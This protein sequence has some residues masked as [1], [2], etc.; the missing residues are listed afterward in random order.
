M[1]IEWAPCELFIQV[2][3]HIVAQMGSMWGH[4]FV[5][6]W[7]ISKSLSK[8]NEDSSLQRTTF[9]KAAVSAAARRCACSNDNQIKYAY[10][11]ILYTNTIFI[12]H[13]VRILH[14]KQHVYRKSLFTSI[15]NLEKEIKLILTHDYLSL[16][17]LYINNMAINEK[18]KNKQS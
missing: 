13:L 18:L 15:P 6:T 3:P 5:L 16:L 8:L 14:C 4:V 11:Y 17:Q 12:I 9:M 7:F 1:N 2:P 10:Q